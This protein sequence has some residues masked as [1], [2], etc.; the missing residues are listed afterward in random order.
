VRVPQVPSC[1][2][3]PT[4]GVHLGRGCARHLQ[5]GDGQTYNPNNIA[6][7]PAG[8]SGGAGAIV[9]AAGAFLILASDYGGSIR[10]P[11]NVNGIAGIKPTYGR[12]PRTGHIVG[13]GGAFD[14]FQRNRPARAPALRTW[15]CYWPILNGPDNWGRRDGA[16]AV[17]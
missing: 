13:Y 15:R 11:A 10:S 3:K 6:Y 17:E 16:R 5:L 12:L 4:R 7:S 9:A 8:S 14:T 1:L 2:A